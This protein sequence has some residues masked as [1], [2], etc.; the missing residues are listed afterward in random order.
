M[1]GLLVERALGGLLPD[2]LP[3]V[4]QAPE[5]EGWSTYEGQAV[6]RL[7]RTQGLV[8]LL[9]SISAPTKIAAAIAGFFLVRRELRRGRG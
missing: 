3:A 5:P 6:D 4:P 9:A 7:E 1:S 2:P 8:E